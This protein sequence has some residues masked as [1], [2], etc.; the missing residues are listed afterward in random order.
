[1]ISFLWLYPPG[2]IVIVVGLTLLRPILL[3]ASSP[4]TSLILF[5]IALALATPRIW[6]ME[7][8]DNE[9]L[10]KEWVV[11]IGLPLVV[12]L[13]PLLSF[14]VDW[15]SSK[16][17]PRLTVYYWIRIVV[18]LFLLFPLCA[19]LGGWAILLAGGYWI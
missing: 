4:W 19:F 11:R 15:R 17:K 1:L 8:W 14:L 5:L 2:L 9:H 12:F 18:E 7:D 10:D 6:M 16:P 13:V 3:R